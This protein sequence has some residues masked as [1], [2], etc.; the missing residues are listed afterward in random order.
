MNALQKLARRFGVVE[1]M[2]RVVGEAGFARAVEQ[3]LRALA[4]ADHDVDRLRD[5]AP[6]V[7]VELQLLLAELQH[8]ADDGDA[9]A[10][11][12]ACVISSSVRASA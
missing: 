11:A 2:Q 10:V 1:V 8:V 7:A 9:P 12:S 5:R 6:G 3:R 4:D